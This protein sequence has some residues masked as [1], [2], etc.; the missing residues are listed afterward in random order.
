MRTRQKAYLGLSAITSL[1]L[2]VFFGSGVPVRTYDCFSFS[3]FSPYSVYCTS[4]PFQYTLPF[5]FLRQVPRIPQPKAR[6]AD[7]QFPKDVRVH[8]QGCLIQ[9]HEPHEPGARSPALRFRASGLRASGRW[10]AASSRT[11]GQYR[12]QKRGILCRVALPV[13]Q[14]YIAVPHWFPNLQR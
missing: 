7:Q 14:S 5:M 4:R 13:V 8:P 10:A 1:K 11:V 12:N 9:K 6:P 2:S 3:P